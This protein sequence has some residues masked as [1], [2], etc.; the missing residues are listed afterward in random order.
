MTRKEWFDLDIINDKF[1][2]A[3]SNALCE[4]SR[5]PACT[6]RM[7]I[8][9]RLSEALYFS[10]RMM[11]RMRKDFEETVLR[12]WQEEQHDNGTTAFQG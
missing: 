2:A 10:E 4:C 7:I 6:E 5:F 8:D 1:R 11:E 9:G 3:I 12:E